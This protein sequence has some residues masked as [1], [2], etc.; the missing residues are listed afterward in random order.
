MT[1]ASPR[2]GLP[3]VCAACI[4][5]A[6]LLAGAASTAHADPVI[7][8]L[9]TLIGG[10]YSQGLG[11]NDAGQVA[12]FSEI[13]GSV[14]RHAFLYTGTP[15]A[16]GLMHDLGTLGGMQSQGEAINNAGQVVGWS[17]IAGSTIRHAFLYTGTPGVDGRMLDLDTW[18]DANN[19]TEGAKWTLLEV[20]FPHISISSNT[21]W[22]TGV[23][24]YDPDGPGGIAPADRAYL[25]D[26]S[27][28]VPEPSAL[29]LLGL[30]GLTFLRRRRNRSGH[31]KVTGTN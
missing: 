18:L 24:V 5:A 9:G 16:G 27:S 7:Y 26:A 1:T 2:S 3:P 30:G 10:T 12:G 15:G 29:A 25:L 17:E 4:V 20:A 21:G 11:V 23:G 31:L 28:I 6:T 13:A 14:A 19:P 22:I 8:D